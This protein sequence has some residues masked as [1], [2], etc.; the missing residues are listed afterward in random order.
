MDAVF[1]ENI[2]LKQDDMEITNL[3]NLMTED[4]QQ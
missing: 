1:K 3:K 4:I 2:N